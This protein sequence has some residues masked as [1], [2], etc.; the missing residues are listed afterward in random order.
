VR[1]NNKT[2]GKPGG[3]P[4]TGSWQE[5]M[6]FSDISEDPANLGIESL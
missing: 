4:V 3:K 5:K 6:C 2:D 1:C